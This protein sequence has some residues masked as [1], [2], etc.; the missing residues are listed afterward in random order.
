MDKSRLLAAGMA[1][2]QIAL[3]EGKSVEELRTDIGR[4]MAV[5]MEDPD[6]GVR[7]YWRRVPREG[8]LPTPEELIAFLAE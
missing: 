8:E 6:E 1:L 5:G 4:A 3:R 2:E 7:E